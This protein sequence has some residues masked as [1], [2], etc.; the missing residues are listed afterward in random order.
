MYYYYKS[1][2]QNSV[3]HPTPIIHPYW[4]NNECS[5]GTLFCVPGA[6]YKIY[7]RNFCVYTYQN[8]NL[9][10]INYFKIT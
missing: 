2:V 9:Y 8:L 6:R 5:L 4:T 7:H 1:Y 10:V 3:P